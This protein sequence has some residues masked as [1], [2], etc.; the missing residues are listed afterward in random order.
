MLKTDS[1]H[2]CTDASNN[3]IG[4]FP[5]DSANP[6]IYN[7]TNKTTSIFSYKTDIEYLDIYFTDDDNK[8]INLNGGDVSLQLVLLS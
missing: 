1:T 8:I 4:Y 7:N 5:Y 3:I 2:G 6:T